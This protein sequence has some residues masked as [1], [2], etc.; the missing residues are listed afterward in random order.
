MFLEPKAEID[1]LGER[2]IRR[3]GGKVSGMCEKFLL[4]RIDSGRAHVNEFQF[5]K[6]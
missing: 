2:V 1:F 5:I 3:V 4:E 6:Q